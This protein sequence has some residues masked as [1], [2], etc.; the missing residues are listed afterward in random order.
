MLRADPR[1]SPTEA[2]SIEVLCLDPK[3]MCVEKE[4]NSK[5]MLWLRIIDPKGFVQTIMQ[6]SPAVS[7]VNSWGSE[8]TRIAHSSGVR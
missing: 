3:I 2:R 7:L 4:V 1:D 8:S 6:P 5:E